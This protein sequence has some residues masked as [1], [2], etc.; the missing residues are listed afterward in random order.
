VA[1]AAVSVAVVVAAAAVV[2]VA[3]KSLLRR[4]VLKSLIGGFGYACFHD[5]DR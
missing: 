1:A 3:G 5:A 2:N 4:D